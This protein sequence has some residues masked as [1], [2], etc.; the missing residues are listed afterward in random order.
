MNDEDED[1]QD[2]HLVVFRLHGQEYGVSTDVVQEIIRV[3]EMEMNA[4][5]KT[6]DFIEGM[7]N[8]RGAVL[9][10][11]DLRSRFGIERNQRD[12]KQRI[13]VLELENI[14]TGFIVDEVNEVLRIAKDTIED[15]P[16]LSDEQ[17]RLMGRVVNLPQH[18]R[19]IQVL[20][21]A[22]LLD[23]KEVNILKKAA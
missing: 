1:D 8:L 14:P 7:V 5:P 3:P 10:V 20:E 17:S 23:M 16:H 13:L 12:D 9:P 4:V 22:E 6:A 2:M 21:V 18:K 19:M 15:A 11:L